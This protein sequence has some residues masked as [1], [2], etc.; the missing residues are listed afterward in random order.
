MMLV[1]SGSPAASVALTVV[2]VAA[3]SVLLVPA[4]IGLVCALEV[5][6]RCWLC[7]RDE[8]YPAI[9]SYR[10]A[11]DGY[12]LAC[13]RHAAARARA[14]ERFWLDLSPDATWIV[15]ELREQQQDLWLV[16]NLYYEL[17]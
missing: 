1:L 15:Y 14:G 3:A 10:R 8:H 9:E 7:S 11:V 6:E 4:I 16:E 17:K 5:C 12:D 2:A 13:R